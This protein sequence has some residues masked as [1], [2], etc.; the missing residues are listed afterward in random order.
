MCSRFVAE[1]FCEVVGGSVNPKLGGEL[2]TGDSDHD[3]PAG[4]T[5]S[6]N[7]DS[8]SNSVL[9]EHGLGG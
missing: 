8:R 4:A 3:N 7:H 9:T 1:L 2:S 5:D 6:S